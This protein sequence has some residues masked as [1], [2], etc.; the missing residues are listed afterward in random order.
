MTLHGAG[1]GMRGHKMGSGPCG[2]WG[3]GSGV[4]PKLFPDPSAGRERGWRLA[5]GTAAPGI[6][7][8]P[9]YGTRR[10]P[11]EVFFGFCSSSFKCE[12]K[13]LKKIK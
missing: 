7:I 5:P 13:N 10:L 8:I 1:S 12:K 6:Y 4:I 2:G 3:G 11:G 9:G